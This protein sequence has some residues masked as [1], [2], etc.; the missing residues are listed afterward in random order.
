MMRFAIAGV[1]GTQTMV[2]HVAVAERREDALD[3]R[4]EVGALRPVGSTT[5]A[6]LNTVAQSSS[7][8][9]FPGSS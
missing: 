4:Q 5:I 8:R 7:V 2:R 6:R 9:A 3:D 1:V